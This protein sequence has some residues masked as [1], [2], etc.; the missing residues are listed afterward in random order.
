LNDPI[1]SHTYKDALI[2]SQECVGSNWTNPRDMTNAARTIFTKGKGTTGSFNT[3]S[4][5][6][7]RV[8]FQSASTQLIN[9]IDR[10]IK[11]N[12][13]INRLTRQGARGQDASEA[14]II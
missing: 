14:A 8:R 3:V 6:N 5:R 10:S 9:C 7:R 2:G 13:T 12:K 11:R 4:Y 1:P